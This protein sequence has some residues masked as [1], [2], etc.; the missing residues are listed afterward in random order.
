MLSD[1]VGNQAMVETEQQIPYMIDRNILLVGGW[2]DEISA[3]E[4]HILLLYRSL[5]TQIKVGIEAFQDDHEFSQ[6]KDKITQVIVNW[7][8][9]E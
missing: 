6:S 3:I 8:K 9:N 4:D 2:N 1:L 7:L 5:S